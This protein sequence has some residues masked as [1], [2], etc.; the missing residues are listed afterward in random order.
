MLL[1]SAVQTDAAAAAA[2]VNGHVNAAAAI[3]SP[4]TAVAS[5]T[6]S[7][8]LFPPAAADVLVPATFATFHT[9][10]AISS[11]AVAPVPPSNAASVAFTFA[12]P[13]N[14]LRKLGQ[15]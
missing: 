11:T 6:A 3:N 2:A 10:V 7:A 12:F 8:M 9:N 13:T 4:S 14:S 5:K 1:L 15:G